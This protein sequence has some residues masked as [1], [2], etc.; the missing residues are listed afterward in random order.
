MRTW[1][2]PAFVRLAAA[3]LLIVLGWLTPLSGATAQTEWIVRRLTGEP[4]AALAA[5]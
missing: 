4:L 3:F 5:G 1:F 2:R